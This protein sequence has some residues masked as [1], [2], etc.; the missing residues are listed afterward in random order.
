M[1][2][3]FLSTCITA[4]ALLSV[5]SQA[6]AQPRTVD[7]NFIGQLVAAVED[8]KEKMAADSEIKGRKLRMGKFSAN[9]L[10]DSSFELQFENTFRELMKDLLD[11]S[12]ELIVSGEFDYVPGKAVENKDLRVIQIVLR[13]VNRQRRDLQ[14]ITREIN[15]SGDIA[16]ITGTSIAPPDMKDVKKRNDKVAECF[17][18]PAFDL[19]DR[20]RIQAKGNAN[21]AVEIL[22][23]KGGNGALEPVIP[24]SVQG[25]AFVDLDVEDTF[26]IVP[27]SYDKTCD[28]SA[29]VTIDGLDVVNEFNDDGV[30][31]EG[32]LVPRAN[33]NTPGSHAIPGWLRTTKNA[34][35]NVFQFV[36]NELGKGAATARKSRSSR[37][38]INVQ[39][40]ES[41]PPGES[42]PSRS[43]GEVGTGKPMD[44]HYDVKEVNRRETPVV[45]IAIR[46]S[47]VP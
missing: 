12:S 44:V 27:Y 40:F 6:T 19:R 42:P 32:Y 16:R 26:V 22:R 33:G 7:M 13:V 4:V 46:Y 5:A 28:A 25:M 39:F 38:V 17:D 45:N 15:N 29:V 8:L 37:G 18:T 2:T 41:V 31:Y 36:I 30:K 9:N 34:E 3:R 11:D 20:S 24:R 1:I 10:P 47:N 35:G 21:Y 23:S 14:T 43:F